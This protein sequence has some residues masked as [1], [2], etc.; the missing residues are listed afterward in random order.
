M[1]LNEVNLDVIKLQLFPFSLRDTTTNWFD[2]LPYGSI[3]TWEELVD[4]YLSIFF[5]PSFTS[6]R[7]GEII[8]FK[9]KENESLFNA[10]ERFKHLLRRCCLHGVE[11]MTQMNIFY[12]AMKHFKRNSRCSL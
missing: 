10:W 4:A 2:S 1:K 12:H 8:S 5:P 3:N 6:E 9:Q 7:R 11:K